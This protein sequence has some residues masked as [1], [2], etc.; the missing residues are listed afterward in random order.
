MSNKE[1][2]DIIEKTLLVDSKT[3]WKPDPSLL[4]HVASYSDHGAHPDVIEENKSLIKSEGGK[5]LKVKLTIRVDVEYLDSD[6]GYKADFTK[7]EEHAAKYCIYPVCDCSLDKPIGMDCWKGLPEKPEMVY[8]PDP[9][10]VQFQIQGSATGRLKKDSELEAMAKA[11]QD[12]GRVLSAPATSDPLKE[13]EPQE[14][15]VLDVGD[16]A[17]MFFEGYR[18]IIRG[19]LLKILETVGAERGGSPTHYIAST[20]SDTAHL[21]EASFLRK[22]EDP[23]SCPSCENKLDGKS[24]R[25]YQPHAKGCPNSET[26]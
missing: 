25:G 13:P 8:L 2:L 3:R 9:D 20:P 12:T 24:G 23:V 1:C 21:I 4:M 17:I 7:L 18:G 19:T 10:T 16:T 22:F 6:E 5:P 14:L 11:Q 15:D 26:K